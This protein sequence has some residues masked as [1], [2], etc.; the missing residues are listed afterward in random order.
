VPPIGEGGRAARGF[1]V[2]PFVLTHDLGSREPNERT[3]GAELFRDRGSHQLKGGGV[4]EGARAREVG[5]PDP[6]KGARRPAKKIKKSRKGSL[7]PSREGPRDQADSIRRSAKDG[8][9]I[10]K[11]F[12]RPAGK[13]KHRNNP[14]QGHLARTPQR[15]R[16]RG[17]ERRKGV[18]SARKAG[19]EM[20]ANQC[21]RI[22]SMAGEGLGTRGVTIRN[23]LKKGVPP[24]RNGDNQRA[25]RGAARG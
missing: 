10:I 21:A 20:T 18:R 7:G 4:L 17:N 25:V 9:E 11:P 1:D 13:K 3:S 16:S 5:R 23:T 19:G 24:E 14:R 15:R 2:A 12:C 8:R 6:R 22:K